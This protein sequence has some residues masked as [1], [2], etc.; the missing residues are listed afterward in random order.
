MSKLLRYIS[1]TF[2]LTSLEILLVFSYSVIT[3]KGD[4]LTDFFEMGLLLQ[5]EKDDYYDKMNEK[6]YENIR[7]IY[8]EDIEPTIPLIE[9]YI[10]SNYEELDEYEKECI[11]KIK[12]KKSD[13]TEEEIR[14][15]LYRK[16]YKID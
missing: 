15:Y 3:Y 12:T 16:G 14:Q 11:E 5:I 7:I 10:D 1:V 2:N 4:M 6:N 9:K 13:Q 8:N